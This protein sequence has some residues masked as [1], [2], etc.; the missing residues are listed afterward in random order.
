MNEF[1]KLIEKL[2]WTTI[3]TKDD[4]LKA[5]ELGKEVKA[6]ELKTKVVGRN[7]NGVCQGTLMENEID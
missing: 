2:Q 5:F 6:Q 7:I 3:Y 4:M 1:N